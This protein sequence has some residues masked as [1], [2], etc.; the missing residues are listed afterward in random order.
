[1]DKP[2]KSYQRNL[3]LIKW[4]GF[5]AGFRIFLPL[6]YLFFENNGLSYTQISVL[7]AAY[8]FGVLIFEVPSGVFA[9]HFG[10]KKTLAL[11]GAL[12]ALSYVLF[13]SSTTFIPFI[14]ASIL[15]GMGDAS[16]SGSDEAILFDSLVEMGKEKQF[17]KY[18]GHKWAYFSYGLVISALGTSLMNEWGIPALFFLSSLFACLSLMLAL[19]MVEPPLHQIQVERHY[20][21]H[22]RK[23][24]VFIVKHQQV[25]WLLIYTMCIMAAIQIFFPYIQFFLKSTAISENFFGIIYSFM[26]FISGLSASN[27]YR[28]EKHLGF[29]TTLIGISIL[30]FIVF[31]YIGNT[32]TFSGVMGC[33]LLIEIVF[34]YCV[35]T[36]SEYFNRQVKSYHRA[37]MVS[38]R[39]LVTNLCVMIM[40]PLLGWFA[41][42]NGYQQ[43]VMVLGILLGLVSSYAIV[44]LHY[45]MLTD[46]K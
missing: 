6:Q 46:E 31:F 17:R 10:R 23:A 27:A 1:M 25:K 22:I 40:A 13:G 32:Q 4:N 8:S 9:D 30:L 19:L 14:L 15:Y 16:I 5:F 20:I 37:T 2:V 26:I 3:S 34:G 7:I 44:H 24:A 33:F 11:A 41:D 35:P 21:Q 18:F 12:L 28:I 36:L 45:T 39:S 42:A 43:M 38:I 29:K